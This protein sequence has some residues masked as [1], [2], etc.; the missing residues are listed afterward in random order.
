MDDIKVYNEKQN[1]FDMIELY[2][3]LCNHPIKVGSFCLAGLILC[4]GSILDD[5]YSK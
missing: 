2:D 4:I 1:N 3:Y 5:K